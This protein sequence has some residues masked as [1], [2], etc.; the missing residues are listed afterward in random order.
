MYVFKV[1]ITKVKW[2]SDNP[3]SVVNW[4]IKCFFE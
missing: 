3:M 2:R 1:Y 4:N